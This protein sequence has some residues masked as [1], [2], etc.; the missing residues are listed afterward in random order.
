MTRLNV[1]VFENEVISKIRDV[2]ALG[3]Y[4]YISSFDGLFC[5]EKVKEHF[6]LSDAQTDNAIE[7]SK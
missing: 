3:I 5:K 4:C 7:E 1:T 2:D 6:N